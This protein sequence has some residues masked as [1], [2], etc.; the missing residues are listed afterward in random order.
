MTLQTLPTGS[1]GEEF[2]Q[3]QTGLLHT[4]WQQLLLVDGGYEEVSVEKKNLV[5]QVLMETEG[6]TLEFE[7]AATRAIAKVAE[8]ANRL[9]ENIGECLSITDKQKVQEGFSPLCGCPHFPYHSITTV[10]WTGQ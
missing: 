6:I 8:E 7:D 5:A 3:S 10:V 9:L 4:S 2:T 1:H